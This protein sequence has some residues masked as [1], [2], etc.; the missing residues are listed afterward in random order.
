MIDSPVDSVKGRDSLQTPDIET[1]HIP[2][3]K[4]GPHTLSEPIVEIEHIKA[5]L[6]LLDSFHDL[7][8]SVEQ[9]R[10][11]LDTPEF[12][13]PPAGPQRWSWF[14]ERAV[15]RF[16]RWLTKVSVQ[17]TQEWEEK[18]IP[19]LDVLMV[20]HA[21]MLHP[22]WYAEDCE[23][24]PLSGKLKTLNDQF[25]RAAVILRHSLPSKQS[26]T[27]NKHWTTL[28][29][30]P[31]DPIEAV[32]QAYFE[33][34][35]CPMCQAVL[36][37]PYKNDARAYSTRGYAQAR[38]SITCTSCNFD[39]TKE[40]VGL[41][42]FI[43]DLIKD[44]GANTSSNETGCTYL[45]GTLLSSSGRFDRAFAHRVKNEILASATFKASGRLDSQ[46]TS[47]LGQ[48][49]GIHEARNRDL[50]EQCEYSLEKAQTKLKTA[51]K[52]GDAW[53][54]DR[55][56][57]AY[58]TDRPFSIDLGA[59]IVRQGSFTD[60]MKAS[61]WTKRG[62][63]NKKEREALLRVA[64]AR[65]CGFLDIMYAAPTSFF[66]PTLDID[67]VWHTHQLWDSNTGATA[68]PIS[69]AFLT[70]ITLWPKNGYPSP[71]KRHARCGRT[72]LDTHTSRIFRLQGTNRH[73]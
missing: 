59:A 46:E 66:V 9:Y 36:K 23:R 50:Q 63:F 49:G 35:Q 71:F 65:Y 28:T 26:D 34:I 44:T 64:V 61:G 20:W 58:K 27:R 2:P 60:K 37:A 41:S 4:I 17:D 22:R 15:G 56:I 45:A 48:A 43:T 13:R 3:P 18:D 7:R 57:S 73:P 39:V 29:G 16:Q 51:L 68:C 53:I 42:R 31:F 47:S 1:I 8:T 24:L 67:L 14:A 38:F 21:Y 69:G 55:I 52:P 72:I 11:S 6:A 40:R 62:Y 12:A 10:P 19:P 33:E 5:H 30:L 32:K 70:T 54:A 25:M